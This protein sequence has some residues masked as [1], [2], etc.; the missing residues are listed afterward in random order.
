MRGCRGEGGVECDS[1]AEAE[2]PGDRARRGGDGQRDWEEERTSFGIR[3]TGLDGM[4]SLLDPYRA[5]HGV[6]RNSPRGHSGDRNLA[7]LSIAT[8][9]LAFSGESLL[10][11]HARPLYALPQARVSGTTRM[12]R[13]VKPP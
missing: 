7:G 4:R 12:S 13:T 6:R 5:F 2:A 1:R 9:E 11:P 8:Y 10:S 3:P